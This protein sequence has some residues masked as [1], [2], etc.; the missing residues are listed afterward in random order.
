MDNPAAQRDLSVDYPA[1][2]ATGQSDTDLV[3]DAL[4]D[5][6]AAHEAGELAA[7]FGL[8]EIAL[9][10]ARRRALRSDIARQMGRPDTDGAA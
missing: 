6:V 1:H 7:P 3:T 4:R 5:A 2:A 9:R 8:D 10:R